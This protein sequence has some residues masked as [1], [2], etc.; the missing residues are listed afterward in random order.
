MFRLIEISVRDGCELQIKAKMSAEIRVKFQKYFL[1][2]FQEGGV[3]RLKQ[4]AIF[5]SKLLLN[6]VLRND[7]SGKI[8][9]WDVDDARLLRSRRQL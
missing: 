3:T 5:L 4:P 1:L 7:V 8:R 6:L 2:K 9:C